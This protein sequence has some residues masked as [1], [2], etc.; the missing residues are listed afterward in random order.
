MIATVY[1]QNQVKAE[2]AQL[3][4]PKR[5][6]SFK[7]VQSPDAKSGVTSQSPAR[8]QEA[9]NDKTSSS[10]DALSSQSV[11]N[12]GTVT[13]ANVADPSEIEIALKPTSLRE[14]V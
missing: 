9:S 7:R 3:H 13:F 1:K 5:H 12:Q 10:A 6:S 11:S 4:E 8:N 14:Q 2:T